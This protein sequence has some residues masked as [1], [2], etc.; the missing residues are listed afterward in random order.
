V[1]YV[2]Y[3]QHCA[4]PVFS[5]LRGRFWGFSPRTGNT[6][7]LWGWNLA[8]RRAPLNLFCCSIKIISSL[9]SLSLNSLLVTL[10]S[11]FKTL[12]IHL[13]ILICARWS[14]TSFLTNV[15]SRSRSL[16]AVARPSVCLSSVTFVH[17]TQAVQ[18]F[19]N[20]SMALGTLTSTEN[21]TE[22]VPWEPL[23]RGS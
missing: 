5:L 21:F 2:H 7:H 8:W 18:I 13:T 22:I 20:I 23:R 17:P 15:N 10:S 14:A 6:L 19:G 3:R 16:F 1:C 11:T 12:H 4:E 9:P